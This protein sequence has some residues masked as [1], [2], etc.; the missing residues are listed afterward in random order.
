MK[1][2]LEQ[3]IKVLKAALEKIQDM[4]NTKLTL[5]PDSILDDINDTAYKALADIVE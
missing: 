4:S 3:K 5:A 2:T 1:L